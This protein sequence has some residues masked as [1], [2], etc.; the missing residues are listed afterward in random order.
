LHSRTDKSEHSVTVMTEK[1]GLRMQLRHHCSTHWSGPA[2]V[3]CTSCA[4][5]RCTQCTGSCWRHKFAA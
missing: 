1:C 5:R 3:Q 4:A 2:A